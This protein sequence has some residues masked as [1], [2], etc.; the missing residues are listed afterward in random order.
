MNG[1]QGRVLRDIE[2]DGVSIIG[3]FASEEEGTPTF[4]YSIGLSV[5]CSHPEIIIFGLPLETSGVLLNMVKD[6]I[7]QKGKIN[8]DTPYTEIANMPTIFKKA[9]RE[10]VKDYMVQLH[11]I[12]DNYEDLPALQMC[13]PD[14]EGNFPWEENFDE[15]MKPSQPLFIK[16]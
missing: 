2:R 15:N 13:W 3:V 9:S 8:V 10:C 7:E 5:T 11:Q 1:I 4:A 6:I 14:R 12:N 16:E